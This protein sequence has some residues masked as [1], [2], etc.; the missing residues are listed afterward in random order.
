K[1]ET[2]LSPTFTPDGRLSFTVR[3]NARWTVVSAR[4]AGSDVRV[5][6]D[7]PLDCWGPTYVPKSGQLICYGPGPSNE[8]TRFEGDLPGPFLAHPPHQFELPDRTLSLYAVR[9]YIPALNPDATEVA[10][11]EAFSRLVISRLDGS[12][13][14][15]VFDRVKTERYRGENSPWGPAWSADGAWLAFAVGAPFGAGSAKVDIWK[16][17]PDG[18]QAV[19]LTPDSSAN[20]A[21]P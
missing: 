16:I 21:W 8:T 7:S 3:R 13:K 1:G 10:T 11:S 19:N 2:A 9:G 4:S 18:T 20:D 14:R 12:H 17:R 5:E 15:T 6:S